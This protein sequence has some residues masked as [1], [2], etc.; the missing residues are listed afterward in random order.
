MGFTIKKTFVNT[1]L[2]L[3]LFNSVGH[4]S[5]KPLEESTFVNVV[6]EHN[7][8]REHNSRI[9]NN[10]KESNFKESILRPKN[11]FEEKNIKSPLDERILRNK[12]KELP[13]KHSI[14]A[15]SKYNQWKESGDKSELREALKEIDIAISLYPKRS[16]F[17]IRGIIKNKLDDINGAIN[18]YSRC[19]EME[20]SYPNCYVLRAMQYIEIGN[21]EMTL[22]DLNKAEQCGITNN[23]IKAVVSDLKNKLNTNSK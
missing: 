23:V 14:E 16:Y 10:I 1:A 5:L 17:E 4:S 15:I 3:S 2:A 8:V 12:T 9:N 6:R 7:T 13:E 18:D 21:K 11:S 20:P 19:I 22:E